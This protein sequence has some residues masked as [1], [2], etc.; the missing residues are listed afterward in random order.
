LDPV[1]AG[2]VTSLARPGG[3]ITGSAIGVGGGFGGKWVELLN[4][5]VPGI[6]HVAA[7][8]HSANRSSAQSAEEIQAAARTLRVKLDMFDVGN[9]PNLDRIFATIGATGARGIVGSVVYEWMLRPTG[10]P[11]SVYG[12]GNSTMRN[13]SD[14]DDGART[15]LHSLAARFNHLRDHVVVLDIVP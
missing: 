7:L 6:S 10:T 2:I 8:W 13:G 3:N 15:S 12:S 1:A 11:A 4:E 5:A 14:N 9:A